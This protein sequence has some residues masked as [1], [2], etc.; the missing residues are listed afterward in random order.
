MIVEEAKRSNNSVV[1]RTHSIDKKRVRDWRKD[2]LKI[3]EALESGQVRFRLEG[4]GHKSESI[5]V[6]N[7]GNNPS[8]PENP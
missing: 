8:N 6:T 5:I 1:A 3:R 7:A 4:A 2:E